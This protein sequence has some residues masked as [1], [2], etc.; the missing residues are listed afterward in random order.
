[1]VSVR[2]MIVNLNFWYFISRDFLNHSELLIF[3]HWQYA[4]NI[5]YMYLFT[6][7]V[8]NHDYSSLFFFLQEI[9]HLK[10]ALSTEVILKHAYFR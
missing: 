7:K 4:C 10:G 3:Y 2:L 6:N 1:M 9:S 5:K 8:K